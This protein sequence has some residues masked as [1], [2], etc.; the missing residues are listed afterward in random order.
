MV[1]PTKSILCHRSNS[2]SSP[3]R[4]LAATLPLSSLSLSFSRLSPLPARSAP[5]SASFRSWHATLRSTPVTLSG[6][7]FSPATPA[8]SSPLSGLN[9]SSPLTPPFPRTSNYGSRDVHDQPRGN[10]PLSTGCL[11][12]YS[13]AFHGGLGLPASTTDRPCP[14]WLYGVGIR[15]IPGC[16]RC[17]FS[18]LGVYSILGI[19]LWD[20]FVFVYSGLQALYI[21]CRERRRRGNARIRLVIFYIRIC[22]LQ[23]R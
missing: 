17:R 18:V 9:F 21:M 14:G 19:R 4:P 5:P 10:K 8:E 22:P 23:A 2:G 16:D 12:R 11:S 7:N 13:A 1:K 3:R 15:S 6:P 20:M